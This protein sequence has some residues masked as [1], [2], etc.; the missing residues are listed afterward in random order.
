MRRGFDVDVSALDLLLAIADAMSA[1]ARRQCRLFVYAGDIVN[2]TFYQPLG[3]FF[4]F[5]KA[6]LH[7]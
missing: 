4:Y 1:A 3:S 5:R 6:T 7:V 2:A